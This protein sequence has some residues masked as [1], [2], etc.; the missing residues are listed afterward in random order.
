MCNHLLI[1][2]H[3]SKEQDWCL[4]ELHLHWRLGRTIAINL[5]AS[6]PRLFDHFFQQFIVVVLLFVLIDFCIVS[7]NLKSG[8]FKLRN[9]FYEWLALLKCHT[10]VSFGIPSI[11]A[12]FSK[13]SCELLYAKQAL[14]SRKP[15]ET[16]CEFWPPV[17]LTSLH[18]MVKP[19][20]KLGT[21]VEIMLAIESLRHLHQGLPHSSFTS[22]PLWEW[23]IPNDT[24]FSRWYLC[25]VIIE[26]SLSFQ[27]VLCVILTK[28]FINFVCVWPLSFITAVSSLISRETVLRVPLIVKP[29]VQFYIF[30]SV[31]E[32]KIWPHQFCFVFQS[33]NFWLSFFYQISIC[34]W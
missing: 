26:N 6:L 14:S 29:T 17:P 24:F 21:H 34:E 7:F 20:F 18:V 5:E 13:I 32:M 10:P 19:T 25:S 23:C 9:Y 8:C 22:T 30:P 11:T 15:P 33:F 1:S 2:L 4:Q 12:S 16:S 27:G 28:S 3:E 31:F